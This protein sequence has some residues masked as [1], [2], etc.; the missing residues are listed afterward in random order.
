MKAPSDLVGP[1]GRQCGGDGT[2][3]AA[4]LHRAGAKCH[5]CGCGSF[6]H[7]TDRADEAYCLDCG[8]EWRE[9][10]AGPEDR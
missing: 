5:D 3:L 10:P 7:D 1:P 4:R 2:C 6:D 8:E 9:M